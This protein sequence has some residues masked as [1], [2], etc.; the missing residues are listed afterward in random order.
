M[1]NKLGIE[2]LSKDEILKA[3][4][5][6]KRVIIQ[7]NSVL[8]SNKDILLLEDSNVLKKSSDILSNLIDKRK[9][10]IKRQES[11][12]KKVYLAKKRVKKEF[13]KFDNMKKLSYMLAVNLNLFDYLVETFEDA[14]DEFL[15]LL[16]TRMVGESSK[17]D[18]KELINKIDLSIK[19][20]TSEQVKIY[21][22]KL[23]DVTKK[24]I[25]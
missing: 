24:Y 11:Y 14:Y 12:E 17:S 13:D 5:R 16:A 7:L 18:I 1:Y 20:A 6:I 22:E 3:N 21:E 4:N 8:D 10:F 25:L 9:S 19:N 23:R 2:L 15:S